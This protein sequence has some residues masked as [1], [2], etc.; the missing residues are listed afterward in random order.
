MNEDQGLDSTRRI[1]SSD[2][3][4]VSAY[5]EISQEKAGYG[6]AS[7]GEMSPQRE[8]ILIV[9]FG[10][11]YS[12]LIARRVRESSVY[13]EIV[14]YNTKWGAVKGLNPK[15][16]ILSGGPA[17]V[18]DERSPLAPLWV[19]ESGLPVLGICYGMQVL[20]HQ[21][22]GKVAASTKKEYGHAVL[23]QNKPNESLFTGLPQ[24]LPV[25]MSH[26]DQV[27]ELP[28]GFVSMA[29]TDNSPIAVVGND[30]GILGIQ[31]HSDLV[32]ERDVL[33]PVDKGGPA[34]PVD[35]VPA[36]RSDLGHGTPELERRDQGH[37]EPRRA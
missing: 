1:T 11:Q 15:G 28:P 10:S 27:T 7:E 37:S 19:F 24:S 14:S 36:F 20:V 17:S 32:V 35:A 12:R 9:D 8:S 29:H 5:L 25:W 33:G 13:C 23:H 26:A 4:E 3:L 6:T 18:Y 22:G 2:D 30:K 16:I 21:L 31:F 34:R